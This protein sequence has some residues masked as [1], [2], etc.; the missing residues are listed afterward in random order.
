M[1]GVE[2]PYPS[3]VEKTS[4]AYGAV[5]HHLLTDEPFV[6]T[7][8]TSRF[9]RR[10][11][12]DLM[13]RAPQRFRLARG[14]YWVMGDPRTRSGW[15]TRPGVIVLVVL[16]AG[17]VGCGRASSGPSDAS[18]PATATPT[19]STTPTTF[20]RSADPVPIEPGSY[21]IPRSEWSVAD[22][23]VTFPKDWTVQWGHDFLKHSDAP[24]ELGF[25]A[26]VVDAIY[27][28]ACK[29]GQ[30]LTHVGPGVDDLA[31]ALLRQP[32]PTARG[33]F[34][35]MIGGYPAVRIDLTVPKNVDLERCRLEGA[36]LQIW[37]SP[38]ADKYFVLLPDGVASVYIVEVDGQRQVF[39]TQYRSPTSDADLEELQTVL[40][41]IHIRP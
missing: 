2:G 12:G 31:D 7:P 17:A 6:S 35:A 13:H 23:R 24:D 33:P 38:P 1:G 34:D 39:L 30:K 15:G 16:F 18:M 21:L 20:V 5:T 11:V 4:E 37:Y 14:W 10:R 29:G 9:A 22:F 25:Y 3:R 41:S 26:V 27:T 8:Y 32:G 28:D 40:D 19:A 36:G